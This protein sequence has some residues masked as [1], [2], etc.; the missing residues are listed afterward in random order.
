MFGYPL[1]TNTMKRKVLAVIAGVI[2]GFIFVF[3][4]DATANKMNISGSINQADD[5]TPG[6]VLVLL[7][8]F[9][10]LSAFFGGMVASRINRLQWKQSAIITG[11]ILLGAALL[12]LAMNQRP[13]AMWIAALLL[14]L[15]VALLGGYLVGGKSIRIP[16][17]STLSS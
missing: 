16:A 14:F 6:Y 2:T 9:W 12:S 10:L 5:A 7:V 13:V 15:P 8:I 3:I 17:G 11:A 1:K 4:G